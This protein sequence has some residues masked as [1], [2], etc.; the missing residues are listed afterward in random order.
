MGTGTETAKPPAGRLRWTEGF[1]AL[2]HPNYRLWFGGQ[3]ISLFGTWMQMTAQGYLVYELTHST[4]Y[5]GYVAFAAGA[6]SWFFTLYGGVVADRMSRR[7]LLMMTQAAMMFLAL[8]LAT[9]TFTGLV[10]AWQIVGLALLLGIARAFDAPARQAFV[11]EMVER[12]DLTNAIALN[13]T[14][15]HMAT[16]VGPA[17][18][19]F[20]YAAVGPAWCFLLN[21]GSYLGVIT[22][23]LLMRMPRFVRRGPRRSLHTDLGE[24]LRYVAGRPAIRTLI[25]LAGLTSFFGIGIYTLFPAW[26]VDILGGD[27]QTLG[28]L[29]SAR[30]VGALAGALLLAHVSHYRFKGRLLTLGTL[31]FPAALTAFAFVRWLPLSMAVLFVVGAGQ[32]LVLNLANAIVQGRVSDDLRGRVMGIYTLIFF[33]SMPLGGLLAGALG[34]WVGEPRAVMLGALAM[35]GCGVLVAVLQPRIRRLESA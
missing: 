25:A 22:A 23:L 24:G 7:T 13:S 8:I 19:G 17:V 29:Q 20:T 9:L 2:R 28:L 11:L 30:G 35:L 26:A 4:A 12:R 27:A 10:R 15:F 21:G 16:S 18:A 5:L 33:G 14:M 34:H 1:A 3:L 6:P 32:I 31:V